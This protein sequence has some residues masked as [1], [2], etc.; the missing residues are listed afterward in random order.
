MNDYDF[1][2]LSRY[3]FEIDSEEKEAEKLTGRIVE[4]FRK[5]PDIP[6]TEEN[7]IEYFSNDNES[8]IMKIIDKVIEGL[9]MIDEQRQNNMAAVKS[10]PV[11]Q[12][13]SL[14]KDYN[15]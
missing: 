4:F 11:G 13:M 1:H 7:I 6:P 9:S 15:Q 8:L 5:H 12:M 10:N 3:L 14:W 2:D